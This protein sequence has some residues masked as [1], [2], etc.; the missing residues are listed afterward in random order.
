[1]RLGLSGGSAPGPGALAAE[2]P[3]GCV[4]AAS[5][6]VRPARGTGVLI[7]LL[8]CGGP[9]RPLSLDGIGFRPG[10]VRTRLPWARFARPILARPILGH[11]VLRRPVLRQDRVF[12]PVRR[13]R[14]V[15]AALIAA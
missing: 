14:S 5:A 7:R 10:V 12:V 2:P 6:A 15:R 9:S 11:A 1:P 4:R 8:R 13:G 3:S